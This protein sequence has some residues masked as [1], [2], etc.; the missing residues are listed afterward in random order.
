MSKNKP[1]FTFESAERL[2]VAI[3][4]KIDVSQ[5]G[6][7]VEYIFVHSLLNGRNF[8]FK[9]LVDSYYLDGQFWE[10]VKDVPEARTIYLAELYEA[11][12]AVSLLSFIQRI[13][14]IF[15]NV[16]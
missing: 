8:H 6:N 2:D 5:Q 1:F 11:Q 15:E 4:Q 14:I 7:N 10:Q 12:I 3:I 16:K 13:S 9:V